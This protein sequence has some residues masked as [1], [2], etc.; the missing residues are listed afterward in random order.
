MRDRQAAPKSQRLEADG[1]AR[2]LVGYDRH[3][4]SHHALRIAAQLASSLD[5][6]LT[7]MHVVNLDDYPIDPDRADWE[8]AAEEQIDLEEQ[9]AKRL[10]EGLSVRWSYQ[11]ARGDTA[12]QL[13][14][15]ASDLDAIFI[16]VGASGK[17]LVRRL[18]HGS[19]PQA[20][21]RHQRKPVLVVPAPRREAGA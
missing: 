6:H 16:I 2:L 17:N 9:D 3:I 10:L 13:A 4:A 7:V 5:A 21:L 1:R 18:G 15:M 14:K 11:T 20:L 8:E 12:G 19:V